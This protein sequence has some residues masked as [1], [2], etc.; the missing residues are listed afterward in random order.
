MI[1]RTSGRAV[2]L[3]ARHNFALYR[4]ARCAA[5][6]KLHFRSPNV[7]SL[8]IHNPPLLSKY[9]LMTADIAMGGIAKFPH[10][11]RLKTKRRSR[12]RA[13]S[14]A[15]LKKKFANASRAEISVLH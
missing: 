8:G 6:H 1:I 14:P 11:P 10:K 7:A 2:E 5:F 15:G 12:L 3:I 9:Q 4:A 13:C